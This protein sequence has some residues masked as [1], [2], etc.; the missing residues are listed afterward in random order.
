MKVNR[1]RYHVIWDWWNWKSWWVSNGF[2]AFTTS[3]R[4]PLARRRDIGPVYLESNDMEYRVKKD[5]SLNFSRM[6]QT[7][8]KVE[9]WLGCPETPLESNVRTSVMEWLRMN[10]SKYSW[11][12]VI[13]HF[14][15]IP[16]WILG[17]WMNF[18]VFHPILEFS[19][20]LESFSWCIAFEKDS[21][22]LRTIR[23]IKKV[24]IHILRSKIS[25]CWHLQILPYR[26]HYHK[27]CFVIR[28]CQYKECCSILWQGC[29]FTF[30][31]PWTG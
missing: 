2:D 3:S 1:I 14:S 11:H 26:L 25:N 19:L 21:N 24:L 9:M 20:A 8:R 6:E 18:K 5:T 28:M 27:Q 30:I 4:F 13:F 10:L 23:K 31:T 12:R 7:V 17:S 15:S 16:S 22:I 29:T